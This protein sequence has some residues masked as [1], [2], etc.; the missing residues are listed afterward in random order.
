MMVCL[1]DEGNGHPSNGHHIVFIPVLHERSTTGANT[2]SL[3]QGRIPLNLD[4]Y[5]LAQI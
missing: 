4:I 3:L 2:S 5:M 1:I